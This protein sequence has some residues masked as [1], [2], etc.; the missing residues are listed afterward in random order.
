MS[1]PIQKKS[2]TDN[3]RKY[4]EGPN[5]LGIVIGSSVVLVLLMIAAWFVLRADGRKMIPH[6]PNPEPN[7]LVQPLLPG[8]GTNLTA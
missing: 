5:F 7:S 2:P 1:M 6:G 3:W 4:P 8:P